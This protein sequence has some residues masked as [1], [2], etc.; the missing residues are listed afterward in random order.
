MLLALSPP[1][2]PR[3]SRLPHLA[4]GV[5]GEHRQTVIVP[6][7]ETMVEVR[8]GKAAA[9]G[10]RTGGDAAGGAGC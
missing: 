4:N 1:P 5:G 3:P 2:D 10:V 8:R 9:R 7:L 6:V